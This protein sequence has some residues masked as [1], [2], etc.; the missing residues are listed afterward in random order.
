[1]TEST[2]MV[3]L[4][5]EQRQQ[6]LFANDVALLAKCEIDRYRASGPGGQHR[7]KTDSAVRLRLQ[8]LG[9]MAIAEDSRSQ[10]DNKEM[11][12]RRM[13]G[14]VACKVRVAIDVTSYVP[15][16]RLLAFLAAGTKL[17][18]EKTRQKPDFWASIAELLDVF[19]AVG[20]EI[21]ATAQLLG[22]TSGATSKML[23]HDD[24]VA[25]TVNEMRR[26]FGLRALIS[27]H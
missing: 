1:M 12:V 18:G 14:Q 16:A 17:L 6:L 25:R 9:L 7:N 10:H 11:A 5:F 23:L 13:R 4:S 2:A 24:T 8:S 15:S 27:N 20:A 19:A 3:A 22:I 26:Q 21:A